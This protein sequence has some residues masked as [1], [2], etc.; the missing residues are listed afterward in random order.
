MQYGQFILDRWM[1]GIIQGICKAEGISVSSY[2]DDW[3]LELTKGSTKRKIFGYKFGLND[4]ATTAIAGDKVATY[5]LL[6]AHSIS[7]VEHRLI[8]TKASQ[9]TGWEEGLTQVVVKPLDGTSGHGIARLDSPAGVAAYID[10]HPYIAAWAVAPYQEILSERRFILLDGDVLCQYEKLPVVIDGLRMFNLG[11]GAT[12]E[13][14]KAD[15]AETALAQQALGVSGLR[16][17]AVDIILTAEGYKVL[18][19]NDG[20][21]MEN[22]MRQK[23]LHKERSIEAYTA[24]IKALFT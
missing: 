13:H 7:A 9:S 22:Y 10:N 6:A 18:E 17:A 15:P 3:V 16:L 24:I 4:A 11:L 2:S 21:M 20:I 8:R 1:V 23:A 14:T 5:Q 12:A 19:I